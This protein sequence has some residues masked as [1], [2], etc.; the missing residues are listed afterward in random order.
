MRGHP[1]PPAKSLRETE[2]RAR[3]SIIVVRWIEFPDRYDDSRHPPAGARSRRCPNRAPLARLNQAGGAVMDDFDNDGLLDIVTTAIDATEHMALYKNMGDGTFEDRTERAGLL[4][5]L[6]GLNLVQ[7][8]YN[9]DG[10]P[11]IFIP[12][13]AWWSLPIR[14]SL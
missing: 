3:A 1:T 7:G 6:G 12:R 5:Q 8:D 4:G 11:D 2:E 13:G 10:H 14:P 9:N